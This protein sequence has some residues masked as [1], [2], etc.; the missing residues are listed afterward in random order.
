[1]AYRPKNSDSCL[2]PIL[3][4]FL[5]THNSTFSGAYL[6]VHHPWWWGKRTSWEDHINKYLMAV[7]VKMQLVS[8]TYRTFCGVPWTVVAEIVEDEFIR[9]TYHSYNVTYTKSIL[10]QPS[11]ILSTYPFPYCSTILPRPSFTSFCQYMAE[12]IIIFIE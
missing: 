3:F 11:T 9:A 5:S 8:L 10:P 6:L 12:M 1:M 2:I 4:F 7:K